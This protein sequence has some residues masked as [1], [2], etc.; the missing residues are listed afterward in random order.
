MPISNVPAVE[1]AAVVTVVTVETAEKGVDVPNVEDVE[2][3]KM[4][5]RAPSM[6]AMRPRSLR[7]R[8][9]KNSNLASCGT[10]S[11]KMIRLQHDTMTCIFSLLPF[12][13]RLLL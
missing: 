4:A 1:V 5:T 6:S 2:H 7:Y 3:D 10:P 13:P 8:H 12:F 9:S 11:V